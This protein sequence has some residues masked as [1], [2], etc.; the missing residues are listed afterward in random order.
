VGEEHR[1][2]LTRTT[3]LELMARHGL[4]PHRTLGQN[5][6]VD[7][8]TIRRIVRLAAVGPGDHVIEIGPGLG[9]LTLGLIEAGAAVTAVEVD[10][11][12]VGPLAEVTDAGA[13]IVEADALTVDWHPIV[14]GHTWTVV[15][16]LPYNVATPVVLRLLEQVPEVKRLLVMVQREVGERLA[17][18]PGS[19]AYGIPSVVVALRADARVVGTV[20]ADVFHPRPRV[21]SALVEIVRRPEPIAAV[22]L[23]AVSEL[24][25]AGFGQRRK[26]LRRALDGRV[27]EEQFAAAGVDGRSRAE[28]LDA[29][30]WCKL[31]AA[32]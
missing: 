10:G 27:T 18:S 12:L 24:V 7:P 1:P 19:K 31:A 26:M 20:G 13:D 5:F 2:L 25:R 16:N 17:A 11:R 4:A 14:A 8:N 23:R 30:T 29:L 9:S 15:A 22:D 28:D 32:L 3:L 6:V 21:M